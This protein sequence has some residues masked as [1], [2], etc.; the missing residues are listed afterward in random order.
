MTHHELIHY[1]DRMVS[2]IK[3]DIEFIKHKTK[4]VQIDKDNVHLSWE[5]AHMQSS[6]LDLIRDIER[7]KKY[8]QEDMNAGKQIQDRIRGNNLPD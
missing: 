8:L 4:Q 7:H 2:V 6:A 3:T 1:L 5:I